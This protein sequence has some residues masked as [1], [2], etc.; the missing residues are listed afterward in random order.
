MPARVEHND[1][2]RHLFEFARFL[3]CGVDNTRGLSERDGHT[4][5]YCFLRVPKYT[6]MRDPSPPPNPCLVA[7]SNPVSAA[8]VTRISA[9]R[10][11]PVS[12]IVRKSFTPLA[13]LNV[14]G[15]GS[16]PSNMVTIISAR[17]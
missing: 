15:P 11:S 10:A 14:V 8:L 1:R 7:S 9:P 2:L 3:Q 5:P 12:T 4:T 17:F 13:M 6:D 16:R